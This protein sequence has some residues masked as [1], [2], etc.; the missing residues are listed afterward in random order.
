MFLSCAKI[1]VGKKKMHNSKV[2]QNWWLSGLECV[3]N[4][5]RHSLEG[6]EFEH[7]SRPTYPLKRE[8][9]KNWLTLKS[10]HLFLWLKVWQVE[11]ETKLTW[12]IIYRKQNLWHAL[13]LLRDLSLGKQ[14]TIQLRFTS[15]A[16]SVTFMIEFL[17][18]LRH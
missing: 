6:P 1:G 13:V 18:Q 10:V 12:S 9:N 5:S 8:I 15:T 17:L 16:F 3:S 7:C 4:L 2:S 11:Y 14:S